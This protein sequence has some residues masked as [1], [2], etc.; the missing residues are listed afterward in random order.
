MYSV[1][2]GFSHFQNVMFLQ[3]KKEAQTEKKGP[4]PSVHVCETRPT[5]RP[6]EPNSTEQSGPKRKLWD[7]LYDCLDVYLFIVV[8]LFCSYLHFYLSFTQYL[9]V[10]AENLRRRTRLGKLLSGFF[11]S[12]CLLVVCPRFNLF[13][14]SLL[15]PAS[16]LQFPSN[17]SLGLSLFSLICF[18]RSSFS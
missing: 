8:Y 11:V 17:L 16:M 15:P 14:P 13:P 10:F 7:H 3:I 4:C 1:S 12:S 5:K 2:M 6:K 9:S 18:V